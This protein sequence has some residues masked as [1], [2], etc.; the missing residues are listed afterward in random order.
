[1][2][3]K[4]LIIWTFGTEALHISSFEYSTSSI[5]DIKDVAYYIPSIYLGL[6]VDN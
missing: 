4:M 1:M 3:L 6:S 2:T 5:L